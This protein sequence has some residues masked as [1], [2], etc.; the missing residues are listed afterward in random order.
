[1]IAQRRNMEESVRKD[2]DERIYNNLIKHDMIAGCST[3]L[4]YASS[5][6]EVDTRRFI[7]KMLS[8]GKTVAVP[9]CEGKKMRFLTVDSLSALVR[10]R[11]GVDEPADGTEI[12]VFG[13]TVCIVPALRFDRNGFRLGWGGGFYDRFLAGYTGFSAGICYEQCCGEV[14]VCEYDLNVDTVITENGIYH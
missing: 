4:V 3:F 9:K 12:T 11:F 8:E 2:Y 5:H 14:P 1:M 7:E 10:S 6:I 13:D